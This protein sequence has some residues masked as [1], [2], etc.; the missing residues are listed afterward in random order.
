[1][2]WHSFTDASLEIF[3]SVMPPIT[4]L[5]RKTKVFEWI[6]EFQTTWEDIKN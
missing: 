5:L 1:M 6:V 2:E 4:K 3:A